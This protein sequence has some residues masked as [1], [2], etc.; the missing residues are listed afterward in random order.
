[1]TKTDKVAPKKPKCAGCV[2]GR[3]VSDK[4]YFCM[5]PKCI[6]SKKETKHVSKKKKG[7]SC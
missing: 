7:N 2:W 5:L 1:M 6:E 3:L 4:R